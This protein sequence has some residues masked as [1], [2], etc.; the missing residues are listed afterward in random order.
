MAAS[1]FDTIVLKQDS[2]KDTLS[3]K[4]MPDREF[5]SK[6]LKYNY[7][8]FRGLGNFLPKAQTQWEISE[9]ILQAF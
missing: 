7:I 8:N 6:N 3:P 4:K 2:I 1:L 9:R 5:L